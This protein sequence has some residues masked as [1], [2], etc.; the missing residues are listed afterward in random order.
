MK[1]LLHIC[2]GPCAC[3]TIPVWRREAFEI[4]GFFYNPN[5]HPLMEYRRRLEGAR[6]TADV[7]DT[8]LVVDTAYDPEAW[9]TAVLGDEG[10]RCQ[11]CI[12]MRLE[13]SAREA[14]NQGCEA[15]STT[16]AISPWQD[17]DAIQASGEEAARR[18]DI[19][20]VY[21]DLRGQ[22]R[23][24]RRV[25]REM[26]LYRQKYCGCLISE[27]ERYRDDTDNRPRETGRPSS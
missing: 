1:M 20:Y 10:S 25:S 15:F 21:A 3:G 14:A 19:D 24:S 12:S 5:I 22:Y 4:V 27:W 2:C 13:R 18:H 6:E 16:L 11:R 23:L 9:F 26:G 7:A 17:H 8:P